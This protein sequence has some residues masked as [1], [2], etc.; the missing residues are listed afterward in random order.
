MLVLD[1][2]LAALEVRVD[3]FALCEICP[4]WRLTFGPGEEP[5]VHYVL[6]GSGTMRLPKG[7]ALLLD[8]DVFA[9]LPKGI[10]HGFE[11]AGGGGREVRHP[12]N[13]RA[14]DAGLGGA[15]REIRAGE[16]SDCLRIACGTVRASCGGRLG[17]FDH[18]REPIAENFA[19]EP[20]R[21]RFQALLDELA[22]PAIGTQALTEGFLKQALVLVLRRQAG[23]KGRSLPW[24]AALQDA[25]LAPALG[26][27]LDHPSRPFTLEGLAAIT[28][29]SRSAFA[30]HFAA[31]LG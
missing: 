23:A 1:R 30:E 22:T 31:T 2:L 26:A 17:L 18:L 12:G 27:M 10:P 24:L 13:V 3:A 11:T 7:A 16:G 28:G 9:V 25:R 19:A 14:G 29:M 20:L 21:E 6:A 8:Q 15:V 4:G 5:S